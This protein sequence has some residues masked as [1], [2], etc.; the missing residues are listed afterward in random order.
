MNN[1]TFGIERLLKLVRITQTGE[2]FV[3]DI[4]NNP[5]LYLGNNFLKNQPKEYFHEFFYEYKG[6]K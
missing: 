3:K 2:E 5:E 4:R 6:R 1:N